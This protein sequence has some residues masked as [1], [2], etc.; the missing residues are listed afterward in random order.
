[1]QFT[2]HAADFKEKMFQAIT[3]FEI[4]SIGPI[5]SVTPMV[6]PAILYI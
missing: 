4:Y 3:T 5:L 2:C 6:T 1:M